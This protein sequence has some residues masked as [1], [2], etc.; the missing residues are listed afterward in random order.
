MFNDRTGF[1][2]AWEARGVLKAVDN[3]IVTFTN[4]DG[5]K[6]VVNEY[7][8]NPSGAELDGSG[9][10][11]TYYNRNSDEGIWWIQVDACLAMFSMDA[12]CAVNMRENGTAVGYTHGPPAAPKNFAASLVS[13]G[14]A[15]TWDA[16]SGDHGI[17]GYEYSQDGFKTKG[18]SVSGGA[19]VVEVDPGEYTLMLR[20]IGR[21]DNSLATT[22]PI[23]GATASAGHNRSNADTDPSGD[24]G[25]TPRD[26]P[27]GQRRVSAPVPAVGR[28]DPA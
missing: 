16:I 7:S 26:A 25:V 19:T 23:P 15:L 17:S 24:R 6:V 1:T 22:G 9:T 4:P 21:S 18:K 5:D 8:M 3:W 11:F 27:L 2:V 12:D 28:P 14:V 13:N 20:A 10:T